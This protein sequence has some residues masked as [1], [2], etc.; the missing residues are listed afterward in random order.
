MAD[1]P[2]KPRIGRTPGTGTAITPEIQARICA[3]IGG[4]ASLSDA[5][6]AD[7]EC[8]ATT[9]CRWYRKGKGDDAPALYKAFRAEVQ[10]ARSLGV[11]THL[12]NITKEALKGDWRASVAFLKLTQPERFSEVVRQ[13][14]DQRSEVT[15]RGSASPTLDPELLKVP[16]VAEAWDTIAVAQAQGVNRVKALDAD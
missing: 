6:N 9:A 1:Q 11:T 4:G 7:K 12:T 15:H 10:R 16:G 13:K 8:N 5:A 14:I 3:R 2:E